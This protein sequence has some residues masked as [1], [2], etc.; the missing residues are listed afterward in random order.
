MTKFRC[1]IPD[2]GQDREDG[3]DVAAFGAESAATLFMEIYE[4]RNAEYPVASGGTAIVA[5]STDDT[6]HEMYSVWGEPRPIYRAR[7][8]T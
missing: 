3:C 5:V 7:R 2:Y 8:K 4:T 1:W 6:P